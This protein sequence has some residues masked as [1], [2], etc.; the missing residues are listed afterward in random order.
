MPPMVKQLVPPTPKPKYAH[1]I[2][3][4]DIDW[5][6]PKAEIR[7]AMA[8]GEGALFHIAIDSFLLCAAT[9]PDEESFRAKL[10]TMGRVVYEDR[11]ASKAA[12]A[13]AK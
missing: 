1:P 5:N 12:A 4:P 9:S 10:Y 2:Q 13:S 6:S 11:H 7:W 8:G 3:M